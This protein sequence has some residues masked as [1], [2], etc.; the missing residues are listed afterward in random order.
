MY[1]MSDFM[2]FYLKVI[3]I[4]LAAAFTVNAATIDRVIVEGNKRVPDKKIL[5]KA[6][7][8]GAEFDLSLIHI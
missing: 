8:E 7:Q 6:V 4:V 2:R 5:E 3:L 1:W